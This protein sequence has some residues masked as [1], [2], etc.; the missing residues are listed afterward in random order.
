MKH[1]LFLVTFLLVFFTSKG[2][3][4]KIPR[5]TPLPTNIEN[6]KV[7]LNGKWLFSASPDKSFWNKTEHQNWK[8]ILV[9]GEWV[10]Q[11]FKVDKG[12]SAGYN[13]DFNIPVSWN[14]KRVKL[15][16]NGIFSEFTIYING[17]EAGSHLGGFTPFELDL[18]SYIHPGK[19]NISIAVKSE[20]LADSLASA[21]RYAVHSLGGITRDIF[22][23]SLPQ[24]NIAGLHAQTTFD[25]EYKNAVL[26]AEIGICNESTDKADGLSIHLV[27]VNPQ[28]KAVR[29]KKE[30]YKLQ[31]LAPQQTEN[32]TIG[33]DIAEPQ[34]WDSENPYL[35]TLTC[36][37]KQGGKLL[38]QSSRRIGF[39]QI[40]VR[41]NELFVNNLPVKLR[42]VCRHEVMPL[43]GRSLEGTVWKQDVELF[44]NANV[45]Y[46]RTSHYPPDEAL[47][48]ACDELGMFVEEEAPFCWAHETKVPENKH[49]QLLINQHVEMIN[50]DRS[51]PSVL[52]W[53]MGNESNLY[54]EYFKQAAAIAK[55]I[56]PSRPRIFSQWGPDADNGEL[57]IGNHHYPGPT[58]PDTYRHSK[59]PIVFDE[60]C[61]LNAYNRLELAADP[62]LRDKWGELLDRMWNDMYYSKG[63]LGGAIWAGIDDTFFLPDG[64]AVGYGTW[65]PIDGWR[66]EKPEYWNMKKAYSPVKI[67]LKG[68]MDTEG[69]IEFEVENRHNFSNL[70][71]CKISWKNELSK[72]IIS[73]NLAPKAAGTFSIS[74]PEKARTCGFIEIEVISPLGYSI[75]QYKFRVRP[76]QIVNI[77]DENSKLTF[78]EDSLQ[79]AISSPTNT[80]KIDKLNGSLQAWNKNGQLVLTHSPELMI[81]PL[82]EE[83]RGIQMTGEGQNFDPFTPT[84][85][86]WVANSIETIKENNCHKVSVHGSYKE[87]EGC[88]T[89]SVMTN[90]KLEI[91]YDFRL[92]S[93][94]SP[95]QIGLVF[96]CPVSFDQLQ[97]D[98]N[99]YWSVYPV[100]HIARLQGRAKLNNPQ[101][102]NCGLAGPA[103]KPEYSWSLDQTNAGSNDFRSTK[104]FIKKATLSDAKG[105]ELEVLSEGT[106]HFRAW[107]ED[108]TI[109][110][111]VA[112]YNNAG[113]DR[114]LVS[115]AEKDYRPLKKG[116]RVKGKISIRISADK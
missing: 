109:R 43:R 82:N 98:R 10:M 97:W 94:I 9:P 16:C 79:L 99:G 83:G 24:V 63:V 32:Q 72:G 113:S 12:K 78:S 23:F 84:C 11:G 115:H 110:F 8:E 29:L 86:L 2:Q 101:Q 31:T 102:Q 81:L 38:Q 69:K 34:K 64:K 20:S 19:N 74:I 75:D 60:Y 93:A 87:A 90:G 37:L 100:N 53:S 39:R 27:L 5:L 1:I 35:Y 85:K 77:A 15:R 33:I 80:Y 67:A 7:N 107:K 21:S 40:E 111:L 36:E 46:I 108:E 71:A 95:R 91:E 61:H 17:S 68:N 48:D 30:E 96:T 103:S 70:S 76:E 104:E 18:T 26:N 56:D 45:N 66:R 25:K 114:F 116:D 73:L 51:H 52:L 89:Y 58:G 55:K 49:Y 57:E 4:Y 50:R 44:R 92:K 14:N 88:I 105:N 13:K 106:Q 112:D 54:Q 3:D 41:G 22:L 59:R 65:G 47:L 6:S 62:G 28:G 42:G